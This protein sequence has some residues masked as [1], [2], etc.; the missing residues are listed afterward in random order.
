MKK[1]LL[2]T[3][4]L[5]TMCVLPS[6]YSQK[7]HLSAYH[8][9]GIET[10]YFTA[11]PPAQRTGAPGEANC[12]ACHAGTAQ[13]AAGTVTVDFSDP[14]NEYLP[15][16]SYTITISVASS[17]KSGFQMTILDGNDDAAG[18]FTAGTNTSTTTGGGRNYIRHSSSIGL[19][20][21]TFTWNAP[22]ADMG[23]LTAYYAFVKA[24]NAGGNGGD[25]IFIGQESISIAAN[26][27]LTVY[28]K[29]SQSLD[30]K[31]D[32]LNKQ[33]NLSFSTLEPSNVVLNLMDISGKLVYK[34][35]LGQMGQ[36][37]Y[38]ELIDYA[39]VSKPG[40]YFVSLLINNYAVNQ[41][42][43]LY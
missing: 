6:F 31:I 34:Q 30:L 11:N 14:L 20:S 41:K 24:D 5:F 43:F 23:D 18:T 25:Q 32:A 4:F 28:E 7:G 40:V 17:I 21:F 12:T 10:L 19:T 35:D 37:D 16:Q 39:T 26:A 29:L 8:S 9:D 15:G 2:L 33:L 3:G 13:S 27:E 1:H 22:A 42:V 38:S 36:G